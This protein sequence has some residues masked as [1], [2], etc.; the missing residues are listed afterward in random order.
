MA[1]PTPQTMTSMTVRD[2][3]AADILDPQ[4]ETVWCREIGSCKGTWVPRPG[5]ADL[6]QAK[7][8]VRVVA[9]AKDRSGKMDSPA[10]QQ[11]RTA[12]GI[13]TTIHR[14]KVVTQFKV[15]AQGDDE[16]DAEIDSMAK[17]A[18]QIQD[19]LS[20]RH[21]TV[22]ISGEVN[23]EPFEVECPTYSA[24]A[25]TFDVSALE[26]RGIYGAE[27]MVDVWVNEKW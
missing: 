26:T 15:T 20:I 1:D 13:V 21:R 22:T 18:Q 24:S 11:G 4:D 25:I 5:K 14:M 27:F 10:P 2:A 9:V 16:V 19:Y 12:R 3:V 23:D 17:L 6:E 7:A 8:Y